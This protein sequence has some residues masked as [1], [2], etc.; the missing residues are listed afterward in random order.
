[1]SFWITRR[2][3]GNRKSVFTIS[4]AWELVLLLILVLGAIVIKLVRSLG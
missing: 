2:E 4:I 3:P 1:M